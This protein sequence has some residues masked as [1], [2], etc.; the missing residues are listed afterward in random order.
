MLS[1][2]VSMRFHSKLWSCTRKQGFRPSFLKLPPPRVLCCFL[3]VDVA[4]SLPAAA[5]IALHVPRPPPVNYCPSLPLYA[6]GFGDTST[7]LCKTRMEVGRG[8]KH[9]VHHTLDCISKEILLLILQYPFCANAIT[10]ICVCIVDIDRSPKFMI[11][12]INKE[13]RIT[14]KPFFSWGLPAFLSKHSM[15]QSDIISWE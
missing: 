14:S 10:S 3:H 8:M 7:K 1:C 9:G 12:V 4:S 5:A 6:R 2:E 11:F 13:E 15:N